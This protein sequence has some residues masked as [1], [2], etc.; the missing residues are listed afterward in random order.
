MDNKTIRVLLI[1]DNPGDVRLIRETLAEVR[2]AH[3]GLECVGRPSTGLERLAADGIDVVLLDLSLPD[4]VGFDTFTT[5][6]AQAPQ[7]PILLLTGLEDEALGA[8]AVREGAQDYLVKGQAGGGSLARAIRYAIERKGAEPV[9][10]PGCH[11]HRER[12]AIRAGAARDR[13]AQAGGENHHA[14]G[15]SRCPDWLA[16]PAAV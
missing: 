10:Y 14:P 8:R 9:R 12:A 16:Q 1:E 13:R 7:V 6:H 3:F 5:V 4:S 11:R 2:G 15:L